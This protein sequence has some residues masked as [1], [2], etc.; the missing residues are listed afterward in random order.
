MGNRLE[1]IRVLQFSRFESLMAL[2]S[3][4]QTFMVLKFSVLDSFRVL[5]FLFLVG[6][7]SVKNRTETEQPTRGLDVFTNF[8]H[9]IWKTQELKNIKLS[10][11]K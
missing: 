1:A 10:H 9:Q 5:Q 3:F 7:I 11:L 2:N 8:I 6:I 4:G